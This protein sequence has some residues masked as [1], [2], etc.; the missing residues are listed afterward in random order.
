MKS[1]FTRVMSVLFVGFLCLGII[2]CGSSSDDDKPVAAAPV[3][4][5]PAGEVN[6]GTS[7]TVTTATEGAKIY[8]TTDGSAPTSS[9]K[10]Y[11]G[12]IEIKET[13]TIKA[14]AVKK[15]MVDSD[16][17]TVAY[18]IRGTVAAP[19]FTIESG[20]VKAG[21]EVGITCATEGSKIYYTTDGSTPTSS[22]N[23]YAGAIKITETVTIKAIAVKEG[24][25]D[26]E[27]VSLEVVAEEKDTDDSKTPESDRDLT[28]FIWHVSSEGS[29]ETG[30]GTEAK[31]FA[32]IS[33]A[34][35]DA[36]LNDSMDV[37]EIKVLSDLKI[38][39][40]I[41]FNIPAGKT[42]VLESADGVKTIDGEKRAS[43]AFVFTGAG[44]AVIKNIKTVNTKNGVYTDE[45][46]SGTLTLDHYAVR[47][48]RNGYNDDATSDGGE[49][50]YLKNGN[51]KIIYVD[52]DSEGYSYRYALIAVGNAKI[53]ITDMTSVIPKR[54]D[55]DVDENPEYIYTVAVGVQDNVELNIDHC[56]FKGHHQ[57]VQ[58]WGGT[59][60]ITI[61]NGIVDDNM[62]GSIKISNS[63]GIF[64]V[65]NGEFGCLGTDIAEGKESEVGIFNI[66][67]GT[68]KTWSGIG[69]GIANITGGE[70]KSDFGQTGGTVNVSDGT[71]K[72]G[73]YIKDGILNITGGEFGGISVEGGE[74]NITGGTYEN[75]DGNGIHV[76]GGTASISNVICQNNKWQG[77]QVDGTGI[78]TKIENSKF[79]NNKESGLFVR[80]NGI[81]AKIDNSKFIN[82]CGGINFY[83]S[84]AFKKYESNCV[85]INVQSYGNNRESAR[86]EGGNITITGVESKFVSSSDYYQSIYFEK[87]GTLTIEDG[88]IEGGKNAIDINGENTVL[89]VSGGKIKAGENY[90]ALDGWRTSSQIRISGGEITGNI[91]NSDVSASNCIINGGISGM[92]NVILGKD[93]SIAGNINL[94]F[95]N[96]RVYLSD[97]LTYPVTLN[98]LYGNRVGETILKNVDDSFDYV[99]TNYSKFSFSGNTTYTIDSSGKVILSE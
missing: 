22:S 9:S 26:S 16:V 43:K 87:E 17:A 20:K 54:L 47:V 46:Y 95:A 69:G 14:I 77:L 59:P 75:A 66:Y 83:Y 11:T 70:F 51:I 92:T 89:I 8:Y 53:D 2:G 24:L 36:L 73:L 32:T 72:K 42:V 98:M 10:E 71:I 86:F 15:G 97:N 5:V 1:F 39:S 31:P 50:L 60:K 61:N 7:V 49:C 63:R 94:Y 82:N 40:D 68:F 33:H 6:A 96:S 21:D 93:V 44:N 81:V 12:V 30:D 67:G 84:E 91:T 41:E 23:E 52:A 85:L 56:T 74:A 28:S 57:G 78:V 80:D 34:F 62:W 18:S 38:S 64:T 55:D 45:N 27:V 48:W 19:K 25:N 13:V 90:N 99:S 3:F 65:K 35:A 79:I 37:Y 58:M 88:L 29:D 4:S 76:S